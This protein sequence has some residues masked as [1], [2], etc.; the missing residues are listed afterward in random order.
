MNSSLPIQGPP[1]ASA[2]ERPLR[3]RG[4]P[5]EGVA[6]AVRAKAQEKQ[7]ADPTQGPQRLV[8]EEPRVEAPPSVRELSQVAE[9]LTEL[10]RNLNRDLRFSVDDASGRTVVTVVDGETQEV[11]RQIPSEQALRLAERLGSEDGDA[12]A[13]LLDIEA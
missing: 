7:A 1:A 8:T 10:A 2:Q 12:L 4:A 9:S 13:G 11:I 3:P 6:S 5:D